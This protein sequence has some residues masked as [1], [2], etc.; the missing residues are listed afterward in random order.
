M[1][2]VAE[3]ILESGYC[4]FFP[5]AWLLLDERGEQQRDGRRRKGGLLGRGHVGLV[6]IF[7]Q[8]LNGH[9]VEVQISPGYIGRCIVG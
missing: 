7:A 1:A 8:P 4:G 6:P 9:N 2:P 3:K 5:I